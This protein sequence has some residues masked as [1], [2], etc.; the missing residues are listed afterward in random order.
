M[1]HNIE[2]EDVMATKRTGGIAMVSHRQ[3]CKQ[4]AAQ[5]DRPSTSPMVPILASSDR[6]FDV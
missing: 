5:E 1:P 3:K 2:P 4:G 6:I